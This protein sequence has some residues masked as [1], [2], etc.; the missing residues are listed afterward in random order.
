MTTR[1]TTALTKKQANLL[2][3]LISASWGSSY[4]FS[5]I[6][7]LTLSPYNLIFLRFGI[8][9][10]TVA[11]LFQKQL[12]NTTLSILKYSSIMGLCLF[13]VFSFLLHGM[14]TTSASTAG[15][16]TSM[17][18]VF[19]P[20]IHSLLK[21]TIPKPSICF[22]VL[23][24]LIGIGFMTLESSFV[25]ESGDLL[26][27]ICAILNACLIL[28]TNRFVE[29]EDALL[30]GIWQLG[31]VAFYSLLFS[32]IFGQLI[33]PSTPSQWGAILGL[34]WL[35]TSFGFVMQPVAQKYTSP[36]HTGLFFSLEPVCTAIFSYLFFH[37]IFTGK[38]LL[39]AI[40][41]LVGVIM[42]A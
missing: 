38:D 42:A 5:K 12:R 27:L 26:C 30:L 21:R 14:R 24:S 7:L 34:A 32:L 35:C 9:F 17:T 6:G 41:V 31:F 13:A 19:V 18:V 8:A 4:L 25:M 23:C 33:L 36:E 20:I 40:L 37:E 3:I 29:H 22:G 15:F 1:S 16:L 2:L 10:V 39:G 28:I 11:I